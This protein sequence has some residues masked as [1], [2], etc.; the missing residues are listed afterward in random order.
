MKKKIGDLTLNE[1][2]SIC[3]D[4]DERKFIGCPFYKVPIVDCPDSGIREQNLDEEV[5]MMDYGLWRIK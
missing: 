3:K 1:V 5:E 2:A 4:C